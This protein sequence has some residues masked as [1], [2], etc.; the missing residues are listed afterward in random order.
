[1]KT[2]ITGIAGFLGSN[3]AEQLQD[4]SGCDNYSAGDLRNVP[5]DV[6]LACGLQ[7]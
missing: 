1:M 6:T 7:R 3:L 5:K 4:V 2:F